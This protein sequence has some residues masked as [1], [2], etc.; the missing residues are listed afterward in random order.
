[1]YIIMTV[2]KCRRENYRELR[3]IITRGHDITV[4][5]ECVCVYVCSRRLHQEMF[6]L[7]LVRGVN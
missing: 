4:R 7:Q 6:E 1:M 3:E 5:G 2:I